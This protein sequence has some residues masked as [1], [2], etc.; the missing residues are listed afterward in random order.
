MSKF[1]LTRQAFAASLLAGSFTT[2]SAASI[3]HLA[4]QAWIGRPLQ[5]TVPVT[6]DSDDA[7]EECHRVQVSDGPSRLDSAR[8]S[9]E[10]TGPTG[11]RQLRIESL[12]KVREPVVT[13]TVHA[14][15]SSELSREFTLF[16]DPPAD[17]DR[18][19]A[20][21]QQPPSARPGSTSM[22]TEAGPAP[23]SSGTAAEPPAVRSRK[24]TPPRPRP[25]DLTAPPKPRTV[26]RSRPEPVATD[27]QQPAGAVNEV[28]A[29][30]LAVSS[31]STWRP[32]SEVDSAVLADSAGRIQELEKDLQALRQSSES[33]RAQI[34]SLRQQLSAPQ[35]WYRSPWLSVILA[36]GLGAASL[37][38]W[39]LSR[40]RGQLRDLD[41]E[42]SPAWLK[43]TVT[44][45]PP[46]IESG[47]Q[48]R[49]AETM[50]AVQQRP[51]GESTFTLDFAQVAPVT[52]PNW[53]TKASPAADVEPGAGQPSEASPESS[54]QSEVQPQEPLPPL[55]LD[56]PLELATVPDIPAGTTPAGTLESE[57]NEESAKA[58]RKASHD[59]SPGSP[60]NLNFDDFPLDFSEIGKQPTKT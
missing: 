46:A 3:G 4:G 18:R 22:T 36:T 33:Y 45:T 23:A 19:P 50:R 1:N 43:P 26:P 10:L 32:M 30:L 11:R 40:E 20:T 55:F 47:D 24:T 44:W 54:A 31:R 49:R 15:C 21:A 58:A 6:F 27:G 9:V 16:A 12:A 25:G 7:A 14:G 38:L 51:F 59:L 37:L 60:Q 8:L 39:R 2:A 34:E 5:V 41:D 29:S 17:E 56:V 42:S 53:D 52:A 48:V 35:P 57:P 28:S 13:V